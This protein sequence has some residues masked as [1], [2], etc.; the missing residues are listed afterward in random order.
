M[1]DFIS[2]AEQPLDRF[3]YLNFAHQ[4]QLVKW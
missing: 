2:P 4:G 3:S 1:T